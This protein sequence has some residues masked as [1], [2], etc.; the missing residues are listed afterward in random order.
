MS[1]KA[2]KVKTAEVIKVSECKKTAL[3]K[4][5]RRVAHKLYKKIIT[6]TT[7]LLV[8]VDGMELAAG[9]IVEISSCRP[10]SKQK[11][12]VVVKLVDK[13]AS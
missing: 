4:I 10:V 5:T 11:S 3:V 13:Q 8:H 12:W 6:K 7:K 9:D 1:E 2:K